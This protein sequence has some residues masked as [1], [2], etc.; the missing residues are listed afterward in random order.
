MPPSRHVKLKN[1]DH[2]RISEKHRTEQTMIE[3]SNVLQRLA[4]SRPVPRA[5]LVRL[6]R[7][8]IG[9]RRYC[10]ACTVLTLSSQTLPIMTTVPGTKEEAVKLLEARR[11]RK[12]IFVFGGFGPV[13]RTS[14]LFVFYPKSDEWRIVAPQSNSVPAARSYST[15]V[16]FEKWPP[17]EFDNSLQDNRRRDDTTSRPTLGETVKP[18]GPRVILFGGWTNSMTCNSNSTVWVCRPTPR[19]KPESCFWYRLGILGRDARIRPRTR[20]GH[21]AAA[22]SNGMVVFGGVTPTPGGY[23]VLADMWKLEIL[24]SES[25]K[26]SSEDGS[27]VSPATRVTAATKRGV[28]EKDVGKVVGRWKKVRM[29]SRVA[30]TAADAVKQQRN[31]MVGGVDNYHQQHDHE[32]ASAAFIESELCPL[33]ARCFAIAAVYRDDLYVFGG[34]LFDPKGSAPV[35]LR[36]EPRIGLP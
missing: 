30:S 33:G 16:A 35:P 18:R 2:L 31:T 3:A 24:T 11:E 23:Q 9:P 36:F 27:T 17:T 29:L 12:Y 25:S 1:A 26:Q 6:G 10:H 13:G 5:V 14:D 8:E 20:A 4:Q 7:D 22:W 15:L 32:G 28:V 19:N 21:I 34:E